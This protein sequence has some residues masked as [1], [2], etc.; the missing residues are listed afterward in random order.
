LHSASENAKLVKNF[1]QGEDG[2]KRRRKH[3]FDENEIEKHKIILLGGED[4]TAGKEYQ[5]LSR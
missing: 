1:T 5:H 4:G 3:D 2:T